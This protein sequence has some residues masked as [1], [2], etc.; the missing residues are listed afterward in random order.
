MRTCIATATLAISALAVPLRA[1]A[2]ACDGWVALHDMFGRTGHAM[3]SDPARNQIVLFGGTLQLHPS[4]QSFLTSETWV[5]RGGTWHF[6]TL[7]GPAPRSNFGLAFDSHRGV[8]VLYGGQSFNPGSTSALATLE[9]WE[10]DGSSWH[11]R[12]D[13]ARF[14]NNPIMAYDPIGQRTLH[15]GG[16]GSPSNQLW[17]WNGTVWSQLAIT[18]PNP[19]APTSGTMAHDPLRG[20]MVLTGSTG[21]WT[22]DGTAW[23]Q[24][25]HTPTAFGSI[26]WSDSRGSMVGVAQN[27]ALSEYTA[28]EWTEILPEV[29]IAGG[30]RAAIDP[31]TGDVIL[32]GR[33]PDPSQSQGFRVNGS[34]RTPILIS[35]TAPPETSNV[36]MTTDSRTGITVL[37]SG[38]PGT[39]ELRG[40]R[41]R[42]DSPSSPGW[43]VF[44]QWYDPSVGSTLATFNASQVRRWTGD[45]WVSVSLP[46][47][48]VS[49]DMANTTYD[50]RSGLTVATSRHALYAFDGTQWQPLAPAL[51]GAPPQPNNLNIAYDPNRAAVVATANTDPSPTYLVQDGALSP[52]ITESQVSG[53]GARMVF[54]PARNGIVH[55]GGYS[56]N[57]T[58][59]RNLFPRRTYFLGSDAT[60]W[61]TLPLNSPS[62]RK[63]HGMSYD[64]VAQR[65]LVFGGYVLGAS[66]HPETWKLASGPAGI[67]ISPSSTP[68]AAHTSGELFTI[69]KGGGVL[70]YVWR[71]DG[72]I[73]TD[74]A[75]YAG[76]STDTLAL[77]DA[78]P[79]HAGLYTVTVSNPCGSE[80]STPARV[81]VFTCDPDFNLDGNAD[82]DDLLYLFN[83]LAGGDNPSGR[84]PD[85]NRDGNAD[86][87]DLGSLVGV[88]AG[89]ACP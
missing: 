65:V 38:S 89:D 84:D 74:G 24:E 30:M 77:L 27:A 67:A 25:S 75:H 70:S 71:R 76:A 85:F 78:L 69:A 3:V 26:V 68:I 44:A 15:Y 40:D 60:A 50:S 23:I 16:G 28:G 49:G 62:G 41:W 81:D 4:T 51:P 54:D 80:T 10:F 5:Y 87:D 22:W 43:S 53:T 9:T 11:Q 86:Q 36:G 37:S 83:I 6:V 39:W 20:L 1:Q 2:Q 63:L 47:L 61:S 73:I 34:E 59:E 19:G 33:V 31:G 57:S 18:S 45:S 56:T 12:A 13:G 55:F 72:Q 79:E 52:F 42:S 8:A 32:A 82:Q 7:N 29:T 35:K 14:S 46:G 64:P 21:T 66:N 17:A 88:I 48:P 58:G